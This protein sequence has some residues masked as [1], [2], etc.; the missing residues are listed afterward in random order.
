MAGL[1][2]TSPAVLIRSHGCIGFDPRTSPFAA[3]LLTIAAIA[4]KE[5][6]DTSEG[7]RVASS[8]K[9]AVTNGHYPWMRQRPAQH[10]AIR[11]LIALFFAEQDGH[12][13]PASAETPRRKALNGTAH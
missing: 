9:R 11:R 3:R 7:A 10:M 12:R 8:V 2:I 6:R 5:P 1:Q 13:S 4:T